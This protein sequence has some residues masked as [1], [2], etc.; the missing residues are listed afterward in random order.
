MSRKAYDTPAEVAAV[1][2]EV[3]INGPGRIAGSIT[4]DAAV[5]T[6]RRLKASAAEAKGQKRGLDPELDG[7]ENDGL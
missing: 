1:D 5:E 6:S 4:P 7:E 2:G 3:A